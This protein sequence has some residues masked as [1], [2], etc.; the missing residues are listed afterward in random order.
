G[1]RGDLPHEI[2]K[3]EPALPESTVDEFVKRP[4]LPREVSLI[5]RYLRFK[6]DQVHEEIVAEAAK[7]PPMPWANHVLAR[8]ALLDGHVRE[9][10]D[11][12]VIEGSEL[13]RKD[14]VESALEIYESLGDWKAFDATLADPRAGP[15]AP[16]SMHVSRAIEARDYK[17]VLRWILPYSFPPPQKGP[18]I[19]A[20]IAAFSWFAF[21]A[22][23]GQ[24]DLRPYFRVP[25]YFAAFGLGVL[26]I[27]PTDFLIIWQEKVLH[28][29]P[30]GTMI[31]D[32]IFFVLGVGF[33]EELSKLL[34]FAPLIPILRR[35]GNGLDVLACGALVGLGFAAAE[36]LQ[37]F[38]HGD[39]TAAMGRFLTANFLHMSLTA[40][41]SAALFRVGKT[42]EGF[43][44]FTITFL[45]VIGLH[46]VYDFFLASPSLGGE[47]GFLSMT[48]FFLLSRNFILELHAARLKAGR[49]QPLYPTFLI[50]LTVV[51][52]ASFVWA[53]VMVGPALAAQ[54][55][56]LGL[57]G[58]AILMI[59][60][61][62]QM[63]AL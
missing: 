19:L 10:A 50:G 29:V 36:N 47:M 41:A 13:G 46:G 51:T 18:L 6:D 11:H 62:R 17:R 54:V 60:F 4:D 21:C 63:S 8:E 57:L 42:Q 28:L 15:L 22:R 34:C 1:R 49:S 23:L 14:D 32:A 37:Y 30:D 61:V 31:K 27:A 55:M 39:V 45:T 58:V 33:R 40:L 53:C 24:M 59:V 52:G 16:P 48:V 3:P 20:V 56:Y 26:S 5:A 43:Y 12:Y 38:S 9:A 7:R 2:E 25:L 44:D 35:W